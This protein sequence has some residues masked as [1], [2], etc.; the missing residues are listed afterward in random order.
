MN[1]PSL[2]PQ[3]ARR[4]HLTFSRRETASETLPLS[5]LAPPP[6]A[7]PLVPPPLP[8]ACPAQTLHS[9]IAAI[10]IEPP[11]LPYALPRPSIVAQ[12]QPTK[13][14]SAILISALDFHSALHLYAVAFF[15]VSPLCSSTHKPSPANVT[16]VHLQTEWTGNGNGRLCLTATNERFSDRVQALVSYAALR[17]NKWSWGCLFRYNEGRCRAARRAGSLHSPTAA[18]CPFLKSCCCS[19]PSAYM[20]FSGFRKVGTEGHVLATP[21][22]RRRRQP[23]TRRR[24]AGAFVTQPPSLPKVLAIA[25]S[26]PFPHPP[27]ELQTTPK[28]QRRA[29]APSDSE[30]ASRPCAVSSRHP[31]TPL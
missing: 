24:V 6:P 1:L 12:P 23:S 18:A 7:C 15:P 10:G 27:S 9:C 16:P 4:S 29:G 11:G 30:P 2:A 21:H 20:P 5:L 19:H 3:H 14:R 28:P 13:C 25:R 22:A 8:L 17:G 26:V 31:G